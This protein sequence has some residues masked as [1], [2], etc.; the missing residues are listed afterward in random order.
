MA[1]IALASCL[2]AGQWASAAG[3]KKCQDAEGNWHYGDFAAQE[4]GKTEV[5][6]ISSKSGTVVGKE[7]PPPT[8]DELD[9]QQRIKKEREAEAKAR[10]QQRQKDQNVVRIF[11]SEETILATRDRKTQA[12]NNNIEVT[13]QL[14]SGILSDIEELKGRKQTDKVKKMIKERERA[15]VSYDLVIDNALAERAKLEEEYDQILKQFRD[16][17]Q[18]L[19]GGS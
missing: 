12:L 7:A 2:L 8:Q 14:K 15:I 6:S 17:S 18:R 16:A 11:G 3:I 1:G 13:E 19:A 4:C 5:T 10:K 9:E